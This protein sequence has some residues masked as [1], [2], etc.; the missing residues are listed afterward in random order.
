MRPSRWC[1]RA[2]RSLRAIRCGVDAP[3]VPN[4]P[5]VP[6]RPDCV[7]LPR[8][9][10]ALTTARGSANDRQCAGELAEFKG[11]AEKCAKFAGWLEERITDR[12]WRIAAAPCAILYPPSSVF[13]FVNYR[14]DLPTSNPTMPK[15]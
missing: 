8:K 15:I 14:A 7:A 2:I 13:A 6:A 4:I 9:R 1:I 10:S 12:G 3:R 11:S 5:D